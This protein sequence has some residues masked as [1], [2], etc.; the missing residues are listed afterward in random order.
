MIILPPPPLSRPVSLDFAV[1]MPLLSFFQLRCCSFINGNFLETFYTCFCRFA[2]AHSGTAM[3]KCTSIASEANR[4][5][6]RYI[7]VCRTARAPARRTSETN[8]SVCIVYARGESKRRSLVTST[9]CTNETRNA[10]RRSGAFGANINRGNCLQARV[11][12]V[13]R[14]RKTAPSYSEQALSVR[15][16]QIVSM[17]LV[18]SEWACFPCPYS[19]PWLLLPRAADRH[20]SPK[21]TN[22]H[23]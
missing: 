8:V 15:R 9:N 6:E 1:W 2:L 17:D 12:R 7:W 16:A 13:R 23:L 5:A 14:V 18:C 19:P 22:F 3:Q 20:E 11:R 4:I 10:E 21:P